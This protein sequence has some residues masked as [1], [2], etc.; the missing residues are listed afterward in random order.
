MLEPNMK[1][2][3]LT[4]RK[5]YSLLAKLKT[6]PGDYMTLYANPS[7]F[8]HYLDE[9]LLQLECSIY[10]DETNGSVNIK[11]VVQEAEKYDTGATIYWQ[12]NGNKYI[13]LPPF[14]ITE[15]P[16]LLGEL[17]TSLLYEALGNI[18]WG[19]YSIGVF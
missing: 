14:P 19:S 13:A 10:A 8:P 18:L 17:N 11:A 7:S 16:I 1:R 15:E 4:K 2:E 12:E 9:L 5:L 6:S 3:A